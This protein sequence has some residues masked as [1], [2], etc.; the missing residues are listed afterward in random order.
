MNRVLIEFVNGFYLIIEK[1]TQQIIVKKSI[2]CFLKIMFCYFNLTVI[3]L[4][5]TFGENISETICWEK[6]PH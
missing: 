2:K 6:V 5:F 1:L 3:S 4:G